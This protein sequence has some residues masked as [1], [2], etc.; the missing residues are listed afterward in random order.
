MLAPLAFLFLLLVAPSAGALAPGVTA[1]PGS[2]AEWHRAEHILM[3]TPGDEL[4]LGV[5]H[6]EA[7]LFETVFSVDDAAA[8]HRHYIAALRQNGVAV[9]TVK[10]TKP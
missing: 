2:T 5:L 7:A 10:L 4:L 6:P 1:A 9:T 8:E 3:H